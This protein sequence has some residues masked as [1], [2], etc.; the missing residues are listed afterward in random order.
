MVILP[1]VPAA[2][3]VV[4][5][6]GV[7]IPAADEGTETV[8]T[9]TDGLCGTEPPGFPGTDTTV[10]PAGED[11]EGDEIPGT[12]TAG[13]EVGPVGKVVAVLPGV[14]SNPIV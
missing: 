8:G 13:V 6:T 14:Q 1:G 2:G 7:L 5:T 11:A 10:L 4:P 9:G 12:D 3:V